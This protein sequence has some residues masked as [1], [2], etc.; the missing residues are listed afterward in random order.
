MWAA[1]QSSN[2][3]VAETLGKDMHVFVVFPISLRFFF[4]SREINQLAGKQGIWMHG[5]TQLFKLVKMHIE[6]FSSAHFEKYS[7]T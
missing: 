6:N 3:T 1:P 7:I 4:L 2:V 5:E